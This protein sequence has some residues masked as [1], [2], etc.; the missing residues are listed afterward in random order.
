MKISG[1]IQLLATS[2]Y[3]EKSLFLLYNSPMTLQDIKDHFKIQSPE[4]LPRLK[5]LINEGLISREDSLYSITS[6]GKVVV[7]H[8]APLFETVE[9]IERNGAFWRGHDL[10]PIPEDLLDRIYELAECDVVRA[11][12]HD[13]FESHKEFKINVASALYFKGV[14]GVFISSWITQFSELAAQGV[15]IDIIITKSIYEKIML[16][17][18]EQLDMFLKNGARLRVSDIPLKLAFSITDTFFSLALHCKNGPYHHQ[19]DLESNDSYAIQWGN[20]LFEY[21]KKET[22]EIQLPVGDQVRQGLDSMQ[23]SI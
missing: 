7:R 17:Y 12:A 5:E 19:D 11:E 1:I 23:L 8:Y 6:L 10:S 2:K 3:R 22:E 16:E 13:L 4:I 20:E 14:A 15:E 18:P 9:A 21:Y